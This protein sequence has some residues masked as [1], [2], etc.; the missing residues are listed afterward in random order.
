MNGV[1]LCLAGVILSGSRS[2][3]KAAPASPVAVAP[4]ASPAD[5]RGVTAWLYGVDAAF[6]L[7]GRT[8]ALAYEGRRASLA[9]TDAVL[10]SSRDR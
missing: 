6:V 3:R 9:G 4:K 8:A 5:D 7:S 2:A 10:A 1:A